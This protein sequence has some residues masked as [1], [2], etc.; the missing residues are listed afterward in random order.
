VEPLEGVC[1][2]LRC[3]GTLVEK[4]CPKVLIFEMVSIKMTYENVKNGVRPKC[5]KWKI[6]IYSK[7][8]KG[9]IKV[10]LLN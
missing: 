7:L 5:R 2:A 8:Y 9:K 3:Q 10:F 4:H 6:G 1:G